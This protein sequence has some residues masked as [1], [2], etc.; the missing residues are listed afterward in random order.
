MLFT[1]V[2][3]ILAKWLGKS[4]LALGAT[5]EI[6]RAPRIKPSVIH[7][8]RFHTTSIPIGSGGIFN[9]SV[10]GI[11]L[12]NT[13]MPKDMELGSR[14]HGHLQIAGKPF[15]VALRIA[16]ITDRIIGCAF[17][18]DTQQLSKSIYDYFV[19]EIS[20]MQVTEVNS[21]LLKEDP[22]GQPRWFFGANNSEVYIT[23]TKGR[24]SYFH[25]TLLGNYL[26]SYADGDPKF[27]YVIGDDSKNKMKPD[28][29]SLIQYTTQ[30]PEET[31]NLISAFV[32]SMSALPKEHKA[33][34][35]SV[36]SEV[37]H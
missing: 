4:K 33:F 1:A 37:S 34:I 12:I 32:R 22:R 15:S 8:V 26:E 13:G 20:A 19:A 11:G 36:L 10:S 18:G 16:H 24:I 17:E 25:V 7:N 6:P 5:E 27:G 31:L 23:E 28:Q 3:K 35:L 9:V 2:K 30:M 29:S 21:S 14:F